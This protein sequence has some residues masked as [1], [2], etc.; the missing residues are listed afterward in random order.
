[1]LVSLYL[2][3]SLRIARTLHGERQSHSVRLVEEE[4][5]GNPIYKQVS[6]ICTIKFFIF[7]LVKHQTYF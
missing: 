6:L 3:F 4:K 2:Q 7:R 1:M 5:G